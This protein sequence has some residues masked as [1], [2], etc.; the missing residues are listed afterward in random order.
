MPRIF[1][2]FWAEGGTT[3]LFDKVINT[4]RKYRAFFISVAVFGRHKTL[5][6]VTDYIMKGKPN[7]H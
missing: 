5:A 6:V 3:F 1:T 2:K 7:M 4:N